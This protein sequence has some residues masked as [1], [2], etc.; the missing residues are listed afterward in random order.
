MF[1]L[2]TGTNP[3]PFLKK[4]VF[5]SIL[6]FKVGASCTTLSV[7]ELKKVKSSTIKMT[8][9]PFLTRNCLRLKIKYFQVKISLSLLNLI[10]SSLKL[11][12]INILK[13]LWK[14]V[15]QKKKFTN[16]S[17]NSASPKKIHYLLTVPVL[18]KL[19]KKEKKKILVVN[20]Q[21][22]LEMCLA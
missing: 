22:G 4:T 16:N 10:Q 8:K 7:T 21:N 17:K 18:M 11:P 14:E 12:L 9:L 19:T 20:W 15:R 2:G 13:V 6:I 5:G 1:Q 3:P